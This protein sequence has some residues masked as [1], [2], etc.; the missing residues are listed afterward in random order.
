[1]GG[2]FQVIEFEMTPNPNAVKCVLDRPISDGTRSFLSAEAAESDPIARALFG[3]A[4]ATN[5][6]FGGGWLTVSK[7]P[8]D[9]WGTVKRR[10]RKVLLAAVGSGPEDGA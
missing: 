4:G 8:E 6:L 3:E 5:V 10:I 1:M 9:S 2:G 7:R